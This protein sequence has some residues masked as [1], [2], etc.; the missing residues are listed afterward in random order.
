[1]IYKYIEREEERGRERARERPNYKNVISGNYRLQIFV[2]S[3]RNEYRIPSIV[4]ND[5][6]HLAMLVNCS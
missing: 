4:E 1:M 2:L 5:I 6:Y 3:D